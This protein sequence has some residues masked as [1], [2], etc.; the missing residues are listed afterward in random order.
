MRRI[1]YIDSCFTG[2]VSLTGESPYTLI[3]A[4][5]GTERKVHLYERERGDD[6]PNAPVSKSAH[7]ECF[8]GCTGLTD[9][10]DMPDTWR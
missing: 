7:A 4:E 10:E 6:F 5:D 3:T 1:N 2:C 9:Y 8:A